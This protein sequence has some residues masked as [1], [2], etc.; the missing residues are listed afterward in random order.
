MTEVFFS[1]PRLIARRFEER[2]LDALMAMRTDP[3]VA[4]LQSWEN[5][6]PAEAGEFL[7]RV[8]AR[9]PGDPGWFQFALEHRDTGAFIGDCGLRIMESDGRLAQI[10]YTIARAHWQ[11]GHATEAVTALLDYAFSTFD[12]HRIAASVDPRNA[13]SCRV[14]V[15]AGET[16]QAGQPVVVIEA[17]KMENELRAARGGTVAEIRASEGTSVD[18][19]AL[20]V[21]IQ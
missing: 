2:D 9:S 5:F 10:G 16:V 1:S 21:V 18:A 7:A 4:A 20:L 13:A 6:T 11:A 19:G 3:E 14:L 17:M 12:L 15:K 8:K